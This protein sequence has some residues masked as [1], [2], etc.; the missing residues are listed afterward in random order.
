MKL[1][2]D[3]ER[4]IITA[5]PPPRTMSDIEDA[6]HDA[7]PHAM[8]LTL[9]AANKRWERLEDGAYLRGVA[10]K[11]CDATENIRAGTPALRRSAG[12]YPETA[13]MAVCT[14]CRAMHPPSLLGRMLLPKSKRPRTR[15]APTRWYAV[16]CRGERPR[17]GEDFISTACKVAAP[18][19]NPAEDI[20]AIIVIAYEQAHAVEVL[21]QQDLELPWKVVPTTGRCEP[22][23][24]WH[25]LPLTVS[26]QAALRRVQRAER[27]RETQAIEAEVAQFRSELSARQRA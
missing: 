2:I 3:K 10:C 11:G 8:H 14:I 12:S 5:N 4:P 24:E 9:N 6:A 15:I 22:R 23:A 26:E 19:F 7:N 21:Q 20:E 16:R 27:D 18:D 25:G 17:L 13:E 1:E